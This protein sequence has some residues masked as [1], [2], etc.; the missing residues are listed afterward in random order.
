MTE[1]QE[2]AFQEW[3]KSDPAIPASV[4]YREVFCAGWE[5]HAAITA[6][7]R[8]ADRE[9]SEQAARQ[10]ERAVLKREYRALASEAFLAGR[11]LTANIYRK[12]ESQL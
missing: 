6:N 9:S 4:G 2:K 7:S 5:A 1:E 12:L 8:T 10:I 3:W 11:D